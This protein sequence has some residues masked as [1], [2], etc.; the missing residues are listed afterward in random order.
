MINFLH[1]HPLFDPKSQRIPPIC[2]ILQNE[3]ENGGN[4]SSS[5]FV[6]RWTLIDWYFYATNFFP[7]MNY[8][9]I[10]RMCVYCVRTME[11]MF[12]IMHIFFINF[13][14]VTVMWSWLFR[15][16]FVIKITF[17]FVKRYQ[18]EQVNLNVGDTIENWK[19]GKKLDVFHH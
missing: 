2:L 3:F 18:E 15:F 4:E 11:N 1:F 6:A 7:Y 9:Y 13:F 19:P 16:W 12:S 17:F 10:I 14:R 8:Y 5:V